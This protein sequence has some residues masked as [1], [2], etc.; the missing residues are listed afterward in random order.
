MTNLLATFCFLMGSQDAPNPLRQAQAIL[1]G[2]AARN[3]ETDGRAV[4]GILLSGRKME[5]LNREELIALA[6]AFN[7]TSQKAEQLK[8]ADLL[9]K[10]NPRDEQAM[11]WKAN[12][13]YNLAF[14]KRTTDQARRQEIGF[15]DDCLKM[16][17]DKSYW[18]LRKSVALCQGSVETQ[19]G[20]RGMIDEDVITDKESYQRA[21]AALHEAFRLN[22]K[23]REGPG[24]VYFDRFFI[25]GHFPR[26]HREERFKDLVEVK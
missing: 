9:L 16:A 2:S 13:L 21:F 3:N 25:E 19:L 12:A 10:N 17:K 4:I 11:K 6:T 1:K 8:A 5:G 24:A 26:L 23:L 7:W 18:L 20:L 15:Y 22:S 14:G